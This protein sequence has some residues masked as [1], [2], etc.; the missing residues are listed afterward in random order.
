M[1]CPHSPAMAFG[2]EHNCWRT[3]TPP[4]VPVPMM[5]PNTVAAPAAAPSEASD[6]AKQSASLATR[7]GRPR[8]VL[9]SA[10]NGR[11]LSQVEFA[12]LM[13]PVAGETAPGIPTPTVHG[14]C[15]SRSSLATSPAMA[16]SV[17]S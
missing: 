6:S 14:A 17:P 12:F 10:S 4:P 9:R 11:P 15:T 16:A 1:L 3:T 8:R 7:K 13:R 2:P 5:T